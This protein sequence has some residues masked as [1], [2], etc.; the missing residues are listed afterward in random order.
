MIMR[1]EKRKDIINIRCVLHTLSDWGRREIHCNTEITHHAKKLLYT[2]F[3]PSPL[4]RGERVSE[5]AS[6]MGRGASSDLV[7]TQM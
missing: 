2:V 4:V 7:F 3:S 1:S 6:D 5:R